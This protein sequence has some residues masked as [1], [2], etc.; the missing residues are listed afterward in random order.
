LCLEGN[1]ELFFYSVAIA[2]ALAP[3]LSS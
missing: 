3:I 2:P 1:Y